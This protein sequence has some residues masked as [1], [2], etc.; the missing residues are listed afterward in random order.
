MS[1]AYPLEKKEIPIFFSIND[2]Y[3]PFLDVAIRSLV[4]NASEDYR[5][6]L[7]VLNTGIDPQSAEN[8]KGNERENVK[9]D[10]VDI[11]Q[12]IADIEKY[13]QN[14][15]HFSLATYYRIFIASLF[16]EY[17]KVIYLDSDLVVLDDIS[18]LY[19]LDLED[20]ILGGTLEEF[21]YNTHEFR[22]YASEAVG[23]DP[24][25]Y[26]NAGVIVIDLARFRKER[27]EEK[28]VELITR[29]NFDTIDPDQ[30]Y[31]NF[32]CRG[33]IKML[34]LGWNKEPIEFSMDEQVH[35]MHY[36]LYKKPWQY[37]DVMGAEYFWRYAESS[38]F[39][40][41]ILAQKN[42]FDAEAVAKSEAAAKH[43]K[44]EALRIAASDKSFFKTLLSQKGANV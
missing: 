30:A 4:A 24:K 36:A 34:P 20:N 26:I 12:E 15:Y 9:I 33:K 11:S 7:V 35:I 29:Y 21:I 22:R 18:K 38:P 23:V 2:G 1:Q 32:L 28:F 42:A 6:R 16:P 44:G 5:Y 37:D 40:K 31:L 43:I 19:N 13:F 39:F 3:V 17:D 8:V 14:L 10:F 41:D 27:I 25:D